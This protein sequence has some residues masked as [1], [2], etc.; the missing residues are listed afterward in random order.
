M[1]VLIQVLTHFTYCFPTNKNRHP[2]IKGAHFFS[3]TRIFIFR[4]PSGKSPACPNSFNSLITIL[5]LAFSSNGI[6]SSSLKS[7]YAF[8]LSLFSMLLNF[9][10]LKLKHTDCLFKFSGYRL[11]SN[12]II[13]NCMNVRYHVLNICSYFLIACSIFFTDCT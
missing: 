11:H 4:T 12:R 5:S 13:T 9:P 6:S 10:T 8:I 1:N 3:Y 7:Q 2:L